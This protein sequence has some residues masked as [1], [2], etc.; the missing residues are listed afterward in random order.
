MKSRRLPKYPLGQYQALE[1]P[2]LE[3]L[4]RSC[5]PCCGEKHSADNPPELAA[6]CHLG[7]VFV[8]YWDGFLYLSCHKCNRPIC[9]VPIEQKL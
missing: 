7:P 8:S 5:C 2:R 1:W 9:K 3:E 4:S 6:R